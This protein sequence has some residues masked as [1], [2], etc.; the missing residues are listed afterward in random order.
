MADDDFD[1]DSLAVFLHVT[2]AQ[3]EKMASRGKIPGRKIGGAWRFARAEIH[4]W[5]EDK[6][7]LADGEGLREM[8]QM[9]ERYDSH[10][11]QERLPISELLPEH[12]ILLPLNGRTKNSVIDTVCQFAGDLG[13]LWDPNK[14]ADAIRARE[15]LHP[16]A[17]ESGVALMHPRRPLSNLMADPFLILGRTQSGIPFGGPRGCL[18]DLFFLIASVDDAGHLRVL[19][20]LSRLITNG[21][22]VSQLRMAESA[23]E[24]FEIIVSAEREL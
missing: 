21:E 17:L 16:T 7:G 9:L 14:M 2:P 1:V 12:Q 24:V 22:T 11:E 23:A 8:Q 19:T 6:I 13:L 18:T 5:F 3:V 4:H 20:Q 10:P 15:S